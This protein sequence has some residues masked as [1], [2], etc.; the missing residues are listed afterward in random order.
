MLV[1]SSKEIVD[2]TRFSPYWLI[3]SVYIGRSGGKRV[4]S[5]TGSEKRFRVIKEPGERELPRQK[6]KNQAK[7][8]Q[9]MKTKKKGRKHL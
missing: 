9:F 8:F 7:M 5:L 1:S 6:A 2:F 4:M 3:N